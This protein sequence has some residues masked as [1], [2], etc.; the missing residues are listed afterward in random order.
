MYFC[1]TTRTNSPVSAPQDTGGTSALLKKE[2]RAGW[3]GFSCVEWMRLHHAR[4]DWHLCIGQSKIAANTPKGLEREMQLSLQPCTSG[5]VS[6]E[7]S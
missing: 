7:R 4:R 3:P 2:N 1:K 6:P 5:K